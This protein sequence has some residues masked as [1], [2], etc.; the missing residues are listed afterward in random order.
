M[1]GA[2]TLRNL[3]IM[4]RQNIVNKFAVAVEDIEIAD[5]IFGTYFSTLKEITTR[6]IPKL[7]VGDLFKY[8][9]I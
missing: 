2:P 5:K 6:P 3:K 4:I 1:V 7:V 9:D 8:K